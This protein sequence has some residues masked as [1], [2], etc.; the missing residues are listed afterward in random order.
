MEGDT[1]E[2][3]ENLQNARDL[4]KEFEEEYNRDSREVRRQEK[5]EDDKDYWRGGF[6]G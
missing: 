6:S 3:R 2:S 4:L 1:W 5:I